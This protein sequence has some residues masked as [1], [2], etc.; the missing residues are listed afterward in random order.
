MGLHHPLSIVWRTNEVLGSQGVSLH[1]SL[2]I[3]WKLDNV[4]YRVTDEEWDTM[5]WKRRYSRE[6]Y[7]TPPPPQHFCKAAV[8]VLMS[9]HWLQPCKSVGP[10]LTI[11]IKHKHIACTKSILVQCEPGQP[12]TMFGNLVF[13]PRTSKKAVR[14]DFIDKQ[15]DLRR[16]AKLAEM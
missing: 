10:V 9:A 15:S 7:V 4:L 13:V 11:V 2:F 5:P 1:K 3:R 16:W 8:S 12:F 14:H 6:G